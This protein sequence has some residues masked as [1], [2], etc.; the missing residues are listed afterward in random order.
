MS[1]TKGS[2][3]GGAENGRFKG[4]LAH[5]IKTFC[6]WLFDSFC[7]IIVIKHLKQIFQFVLGT[8]NLP[9]ELSETS[10]GKTA[11]QRMTLKNGFTCLI[12]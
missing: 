9:T 3:F 8:S 4:K 2:I 1:V 10:Y 11:V 6:D 12:A 5:I 7:H